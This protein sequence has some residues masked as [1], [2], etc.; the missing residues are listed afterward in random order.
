MKILLKLVALGCILCIVRGASIREERCTLS[1]EG[2]KCTLTEARLRDADYNPFKI[3]VDDPAKIKTFEAKKCEMHTFSD[4]VCKAFP[5]LENIIL[6]QVQML[7][8]ENDAFCS[9]KKLHSLIITGNMFPEIGQYTFSK[10]TELQ[11]VSLVSNFL[12]DQDLISLNSLDN[13]RYLSVAANFITEVPWAKCRIFPNLQD[14]DVS[15][16]ELV[17]INATL[18]IKKFPK[19]KRINISKNQFNCPVERVFYKDV[20]QLKHQLGEDIIVVDEFCLPSLKFQIQ[21]IRQLHQVKHR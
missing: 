16:N 8:I 12:D 20:K 6:N 19:L 3:I 17:S 4:T 7:E 2:T 5:N 14:L 15:H 18:L 9:C 13:L 1:H 10:N 11:Y 21:E